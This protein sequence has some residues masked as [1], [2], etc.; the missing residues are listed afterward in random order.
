MTQNTAEPAIEPRMRK[1]RQ[2]TISKTSSLGY[3]RAYSQMAA[4]LQ[5]TTATSASFVNEGRSRDFPTYRSLSSSVSRYNSRLYP[6]SPTTLFQIVELLPADHPLRSADYTDV[7]GN[8]PL[9]IQYLDTVNVGTTTNS[10]DIMIIMFTDETLQRI[11]DCTKVHMDGT[12]K[13]VP[14]LFRQ[15][16]R[17]SQLFTIHGYGGQ[18]LF[19]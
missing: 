5:Q 16:N 2:Q 3:G 8:A 15:H 7:Y 18:R 4:S 12:F 14:E 10:T 6:P 13:I 11:C 9:F 19:P 17:S 1:A